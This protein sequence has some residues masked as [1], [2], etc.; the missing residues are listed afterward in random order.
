MMTF[1]VTRHILDGEPSITIVPVEQDHAEGT[2]LAHI[3][4]DDEGR[5]RM[6]W[7]D[8]SCQSC[9][10]ADIG[11]DDPDITM[12]TDIRCGC[13]TCD[14]CGALVDPGRNQCD[15][16]MLPMDDDECDC[17]PHN[18]DADTKLSRIGT[19]LSDLLRETEDIE[20][21]EPGDFDRESEPETLREVAWQQEGYRRGL[22][23]AV[24]D[25][26]EVMGANIGPVPM[27]P[28]AWPVR[29]LAQ[30]AWNAVLETAHQDREGHPD[31]RLGQ[32]VSNALSRAYSEP[33]WGIR[34]AGFDPFDDDSKI[35]ECGRYFR[36]AIV[37]KIANATKAPKRLTPDQW[38]EAEEEKRA[39]PTH[40]PND[41]T[42]LVGVPH[43]H[44]LHC[45]A[46]GYTWGR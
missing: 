25:I 46:C 7:L 43:D 41:G 24:S 33:L 17:P 16:C 11:T 23:S 29:H 32:A 19:I 38:V 9:G 15:D 31:Y 26:L 28:L 39:E 18:P 13:E 21:H 2:L 20:A 42:V 12:H 4:A 10:F 35:E 37:E 40:C 34:N 45:G 30:S 5:A 3:Q 14:D 44:D 36:A 6:A 8:W 1:A 27:K 22:L